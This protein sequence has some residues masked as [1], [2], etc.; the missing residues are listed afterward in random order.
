M[1][2]VRACDRPLLLLF[3]TGW[4]LTEELLAGVDRVLR[5]IQG[6]SDYNHL[7]VRAAVAIM[8]DRLFGDREAPPTSAAP[9]AKEAAPSGEA[10]P[11]LRQP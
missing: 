2:E 6:N 4:G 9:P 5:P 1:S 10:P 11:L 8:L 7:S 3:G